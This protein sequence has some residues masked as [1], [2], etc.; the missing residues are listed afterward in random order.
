MI[1]WIFLVKIFFSIKFAD[2]FFF[3]QKR[4]IVIP[5]DLWISL[6]IIHMIISIL[7]HKHIIVDF[8][9]RYMKLYRCW[10][11]HFYKSLINIPLLICFGRHRFLITSRASSLMPY[12][13]EKFSQKKPM[14]VYIFICKLDIFPLRYASDKSLDYWTDIDP[15]K[16]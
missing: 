3:S 13:Y 2:N 7:W 16:Y 12:C 5:N 11:H 9:V 8:Y 15:Q 6:L 4:H 1:F 14:I 10:W